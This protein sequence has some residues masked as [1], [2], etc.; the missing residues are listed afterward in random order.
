MPLR[1]QGYCRRPHGNMAVLKK[2]VSSPVA[3]TLQSFYSAA[4][5]GFST[6]GSKPDGTQPPGTAY[7]QSITLGAS[8]FNVVDVDACTWLA[9]W[10]AARTTDPLLSQIAINANQFPFQNAAAIPV[11]VG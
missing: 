10:V 6:Y 9:S 5:S 8:A 4:S 3:L 11:V 2:Y 1:F 7:R